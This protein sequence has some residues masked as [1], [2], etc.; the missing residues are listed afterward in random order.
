MWCVLMDPDQR[1]CM[2]P[3]TQLGE[4]REDDEWRLLTKEFTKAEAGKYVE[5]CWTDMVPKGHRDWLRTQDHPD[6]K[7][8][9]DDQYAVIS[10]P[11]RMTEFARLKKEAYDKGKA[12]QDA[13]DAAEDA[14]L[15][16]AAAE[17]ATE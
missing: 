6:Y 17:E 1:Y 14:K 3:I 7:D 13:I 9:T 12:A 10:M 2:I 8:L 5:L 11:M 4:R 15:A 16:D